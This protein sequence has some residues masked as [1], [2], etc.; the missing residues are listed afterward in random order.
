MPTPT[1]YE[2]LLTLKPVAPGLWVCDGPVISFYGLPFPT[3]M[4]VVQLEGGGLFVHSPVELSAGVVA[5]VTALGPV[6][7]LIAPNWIHYA[8]VPAWQAAFP[9]ATTWA[10]P[11]VQERAAAFRVRLHVDHPLDGGVPAAWT[12]QIEQL[13]ARGSDV[14]QEVVFFHRATR[15][16][17]LTDLIENFEAQCC[18]AWTRPLLLLA[19]TRDPDGKAPIDMRL[20]FRFGE[21]GRG[22]GLLRAAVEQMLAWDPERVI[23]AHGRWYRTNGT[24]ELRRA[25]RWALG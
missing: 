20:S 3:R 18:P 25:F 1:G 24:A 19:G 5:E 13:L 8:H 15:T 11:R 16:L 6:E 21:G 7:H 14:H 22:M 9:G 17:L 23:L 4:T 12:G 10:A 2:P